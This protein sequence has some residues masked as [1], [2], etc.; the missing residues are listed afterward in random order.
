[1]KWNKEKKKYMQIYIRIACVRVGSTTI[2]KLRANDTTIKSNKKSKTFAI[3][4]RCNISINC[5]CNA[6]IIYFYMLSWWQNMG[7]RAFSVRVGRCV[8]SLFCLHRT[9]ERRASRLDSWRPNTFFSSD[10]S[11]EYYN[12]IPFDTVVRST[13]GPPSTGTVRL[14]CQKLFIYENH[15]S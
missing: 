3:S 11:F 9:R 2:W 7:R 15:H 12:E 4:W 14:S 1:M 13:D 5:N 10:D 8:F 6:W